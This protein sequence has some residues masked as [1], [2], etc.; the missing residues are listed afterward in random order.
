MGFSIILVRPSP[1]ALTYGAATQTAVLLY[2]ERFF[3]FF[4]YTENTVRPSETLA[5][6]CFFCVYEIILLY[7]FVNAIFFFLLTLL[8]ENVSVSLLVQQYLVVF[9]FY[10]SPFVLLYFVF[11][12][13]I[14][15]FLNEVRSALKYI[16]PTHKIPYPQGDWW[17]VVIPSLCVYMY[18][19]CHFP[20][21]L[22]VFFL[23]ASLPWHGTASKQVI[24]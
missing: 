9:F 14:F 17:S 11:C 8:T 5:F 15:L 12:I 7:S 22:F 13:C 1:A 21:C 4:H 3:L 18:E 10:E 2:T 6:S 16:L 24:I 23:D 19:K 20:R